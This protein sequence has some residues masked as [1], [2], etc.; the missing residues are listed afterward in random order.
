LKETAWVVD[1]LEKLAEGLQPQ[2]SVEE[3]IDAEKIVRKDLTVRK[4]AADVGM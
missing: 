1:S 3:L 4:L 2:V